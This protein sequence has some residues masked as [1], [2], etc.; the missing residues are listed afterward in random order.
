MD[1]SEPF[2]EELY[3]RRLEEGYDVFDEKYVRW[4]LLKH[5]DKVK[6]DWLEKMPTSSKQS[7]QVILKYSSVYEA[8]NRKRKNPRPVVVG[9]VLDTQQNYI[10]K[11]LIQEVA[12]PK[13]KTKQVRVS[14]ARVLTSDECM[15][16]VQEQKRKS[17]TIAE[18]KGREGSK[19]ET[20]RNI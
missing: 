14:G 16:I 17:L 7:S 15:K 11:Y 2:D 19:K 20:K 8:L 4:L 3:K 9:P 1:K 18:K 13:E 10:S 12:L 6:S 5:P